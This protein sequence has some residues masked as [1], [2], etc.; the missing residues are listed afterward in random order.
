M[1]GSV[2]SHCH[3]LPTVPL[4]SCAAAVPSA[5]GGGAIFSDVGLAAQL[6]QSDFGDECRSV[7]LVDAAPRMA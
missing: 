6:L 4:P 5:G 1:I 2:A 3:K 7:L